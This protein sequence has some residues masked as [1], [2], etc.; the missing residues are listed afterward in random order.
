MCGICGLFNFEP[1]RIIQPEAIRRMNAALQHRG[2]DDEGFYYKD[3]LALGMRRLSIIDLD[4]GRQPIHNEDE[5]VWVVFNGEVY[6]YLELRRAL[7]ARGHSFYTRSDTETLVHAYEEWGQDFLARLRGMF[8]F[9]LWDEKT[10]T[11]FL[12][13]DRLG[14][15]PLY[16]YYDQNKKW[17]AF[18]SEI[19]ALLQIPN[20]PRGVDLSALEAFLSF[21]YVPGPATMLAGICKLPPGHLLQVAEGRLTIKEYWDLPD[22]QTESR[23][24]AESCQKLRH[25]LEESIR[26]RLISDVPLGAFLSG[27]IDSGTVVGLMSRTMN[28]PV[29][30]FSVGFAE[31]EH[32]E[33]EYARLI[34]HHF[35][36]DHHEIMVKNCPPEL[37]RQ[38]VW[39]L[40]E[41]LA[42]P[43]A[44]P[45]Y[46]VSKLAR[47]E[48]TV[49]LTGE[50][51]D[52]LFA[53][54]W[55]YRREKMMS[56]YR[57][58]PRAVRAGLIPIL[59]RA[60]TNL[61]PT[62]RLERIV[63]RG[64]QSPARGLHTWTVV[65]T[66]AEKQALLAL[67]ERDQTCQPGDGWEVMEALYERSLAFD[68]LN[69]WLYLDAKI[70]LP[71][72]LLM[73]VDKMSM[74]T[75]LEARCPFLDHQ[76]MEFVAT[77]PPEL[78]LNGATS[79]YILKKAVA[80]LLPTAIIRRP[81][82]TFDVPL[83]RW[84]REDLRDL[85][86]DMFSPP[87]L[88]AQGLF[89][90]AY[91]TQLWQHLEEG[92]TRLVARQLWTLLNF[93]LWS[94]L[95]EGT[96]SGRGRDYQETFSSQYVSGLSISRISGKGRD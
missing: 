35:E 41:P 12:V 76:L 21:Q 95:Y 60:F 83:A 73:K 50:G 77:L 19:K 61:K 30:T 71:D 69:R 9:A 7:E 14:Q 49:V 67:D 10:K 52:E 48:V 89:D 32:N 57:R 47:Q 8:A 13:R 20:I 87:R 3:S 38:V 15:K 82:H 18:A 2:P 37:L 39:Y 28:Q 36:T 75:S 16:Y 59:A 72:D 54:Y 34:A 53:G 17:L 5:T 42:D 46:L 33:L 91:V 80:D 23:S 22:K 92:R 6:N 43:A 62:P 74:A 4:G 45:T 44:I 94:E 68:E 85:A 26:L 70:W 93:Q 81:K 31:E 27:G 11:L 29:K 64:T 51:A 40:D 65:F 55:Y 63:W 1:E 90:P 58:L 84:L 24:P 88:K 78:K 66:P 79:K 56:R 86:L 96:L 25:L